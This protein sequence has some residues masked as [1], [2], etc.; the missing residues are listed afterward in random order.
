MSLSLKGKTAIIT[1]ASSGIG[2]AI[3]L[4][5]AELGLHLILTAR[6]DQLLG[7][8][9]QEI[10]KKHKVQVSTY[11]F[12]V[13]N[14]TECEHFVAEI[15][16]HPI[17]ILINNAG[18]ALGVDPVNT[19]D[20][21]DWETMIDTNIKG[22]LYMTRL[23]SPVMVKQKSGHIVNMGSIAGHEAYRGGSVY[24]ATKHAVKAINT[25]MKMDLSGTGIRV[26]MVSPGMVETDFSNIRFHG[27]TER[28]R[29]VYEGMTPLSAEDIADLVTF[30][31]TRPSH[32]DIMDIL[33]YP[34]AQ[35]SSYLVHRE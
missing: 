9:S 21:Q 26:S 1:G 28:A 35:S 29:K 23:I 34:T 32:V 6:R 27:D 12:D 5:F 20:L 14:R 2:R 31:V 10:K 8:L 24:C 11:A 33:V 30:I 16:S 4:Q 22:L 18:L 17:D 3:A 25:S 7:E 19:A 13:S 15:A